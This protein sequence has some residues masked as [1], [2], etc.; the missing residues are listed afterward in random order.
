MAGPLDQKVKIFLTLLLIAL[1]GAPIYFFTSSTH[2]ALEIASVKVLGQATPVKV[3][4]SNPHGTRLLLIAVEQDGKSYTLP[5]VSQPTRRF[6]VE[7]HAAPHNL[8]VSLGKQAAPA[9]HDGKARIVVTAVSNDLRANTDSKSIDVEVI[10][11]PPRIAADG[12]QHYINQ[13]GSEM[14]VFTPGGAWTEAGVKVGDRVFRGFPLPDHPGQYFS[15]FAFTWDR[16]PDTP[17][18]V[19]ATN[20]T[21]ATASATFWYKIFPKQFRASTIKLEDMHVDRIVGQI[22]PE[23]KIKGDLIERFVKINSEMRLENNKALADLRFQSEP[24]FLWTGAFLP[25][26]DSAIESRFADRRTYTWQ[27]K[28]VDEQVH[29]GFDLAKVA[30][31]PVPAANDGKVIFADN[32]GIYG[33]CI[34]LDHGFGLQ[35]IYGHMSQFEV[36]K[37]DVVKRGQELGRTGSTGLAGGDHLHF[38]MQVDG[39]Q[40]NPVEWWDPHWI[41]DRI[42]SK[43]GASE[44]EPTAPPTPARNRSGKRRR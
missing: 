26:V 34:V 35:T 28:K 27:G 16:S 18:S 41:H 44:P 39:V 2:T 8:T 12:A 31:S 4:T 15:L 43:T 38:T 29:L 1:I 42:L 24:K 33:N 7:R 20:P 17:L 3:Q 14:V 11:V 13:G 40:V 23:G 36:K 37:G 19:V 32:L 5:P 22:D 10:T 21:G 6:F 30:H 9:L 25:M